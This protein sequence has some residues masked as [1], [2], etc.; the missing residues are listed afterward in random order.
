[1]T[2]QHPQVF[3]RL[4]GCLAHS[5]ADGGPVPEIKDQQTAFFLAQAQTPGV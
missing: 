2:A 1:M 4:A 5:F 3:Q